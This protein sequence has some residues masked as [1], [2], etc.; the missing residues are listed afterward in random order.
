MRMSTLF[1]FPSQKPTTLCLLPCYPQVAEHGSSHSFFVTFLLYEVVQAHAP[2]SLAKHNAIGKRDPLLDSGLVSASWIWTPDATIGNVAFLKTFS[3]AAGKT[4]ISASISMT[5]VNQFTLWV[6]GQPI[7]ASG[8]GPDDW[9]SA[10]VLDA[11]LNATSANTFSVLA[12]NKANAGGPA[13]GLLAAIRVKYLDGSSESVVSDSSWAVSATIPPDFPTPAD[14]THFASAAV[15]AP[16]GSGVWGRSVAIAAADPNVPSLASSSWIW[17][18][19]TAATEAPVGTV[20]FRKTVVSPSGKTA[21]SALIVVAVDNGYTLY[22]N[23]KYV[24]APPGHPS[25]PDFKRGQQFKVDLSASSNTIT[26]FGENIAAPG[27]TGAG[28]AGFVAAI[29]IQ[30]SDGSSDLVGTDATWLSGA[31]TTV[32]AFFSTADSA[33]SPAFAIGAMGAAPWGALDG[34][35]NALAAVNVPAGP[36]ASGTLPQAPPNTVSTGSATVASV[37]AAQTDSATRVSATFSTSRPS[38]PA[39]AVGLV[40]SAVPSGSGSALP[41]LAS[42]G[43]GV[44]SNSPSTSA[45]PAAAASAHVPTALIVVLVVGALALI[46]VGLGLFC[47]RRRQREPRRHKRIQST[48]L[49]AAANASASAAGQAS[50]ASVASDSRRTSLATS[51]ASI[52]RAE[53]AWLQPQR[54]MSYNFPPVPGPQPDVYQ[55]PLPPVSIPQPAYVGQPAYAGS[56]QAEAAA[57]GLGMIPPTKLEH[58]RMIWQQNANAAAAARRLS[59][60]P[61]THSSRASS[62][63]TTYYSRAS[64]VLS[65]VD[66][67]YGGLEPAADADAC[68]SS[69]PPGYYAH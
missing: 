13:P 9:K 69:P 18:I 2:R 44:D 64:S 12:V 52:R 57:P 5:A 17:S 53:M 60:V 21:T 11:A 47:W 16:F 51:E 23:E 55:Q 54:A 42:A 4:A 26:V 66:A 50:V 22:V 59:A 25:I 45:A 67:A 65:E 28:P 40:G 30:Y 3:S 32:P 68:A 24:G 41:P 34:V 63:P 61:T 6:N 58:E 49:F 19:S 31:F 48:Q 14:T 7:G 39:S 37:A 62:V 10:Q 56:S 35:S 36:F 29:R 1:P 38:T 46:A 8:D 43:S 27:T 15:A 20:G 33:L